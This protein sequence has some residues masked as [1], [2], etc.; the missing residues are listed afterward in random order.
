MPR[1]HITLIGRVGQDP[2]S[3]EVGDAEVCNF[4]V[5]A[6]RK[7]KGEDVTDWFNVS[8]WGKTGQLCQEHLA[9][10]SQVAVIGGLE[11]RTYEKDGVK[12]TSLDVRASEVHFIGQKVQKEELPHADDLPP[13]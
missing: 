2:T 10:G 3:R 9:K 11:P 6:G 4:S 13:F 1:A 12:Q 5:A 8:A 7:V